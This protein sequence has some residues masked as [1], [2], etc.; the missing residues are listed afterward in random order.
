M[1]GDPF[2]NGQGLFQVFWLL[3]VYGWGVILFAVPVVLFDYLGYRK[4]VEFP[5][6]FDAMPLWAKTLLIAALV[7]LIQF[8]ARREAN[9]FI[10]FAF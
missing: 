3:T 1:V 8:F 9:E 7:Y 6:L 5:E 4:G 2:E 10:Y